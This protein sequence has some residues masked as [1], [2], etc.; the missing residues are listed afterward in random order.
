MAGNEIRRKFLDYFAER[1]HRI[2]QARRLLGSSASDPTLL[3]TNP[4]MKGACILQN[5]M[6]RSSCEK[7]SII[8][9]SDA[10]LTRK[11]TKQ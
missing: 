4:G 7:A 6:I 2:L 10:W 8:A 5:N 11:E 1:T 9:A 3:F